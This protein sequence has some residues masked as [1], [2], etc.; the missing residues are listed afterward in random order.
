MYAQRSGKLS[1]AV[2]NP[3]PWR[4]DSHL[5]DPVVGAW[6]KEGGGEGGGG[7][8]CVGALCVQALTVMHS[9]NTSR[10]RCPC[11]CVSKPPPPPHP[12][13]GFYDAGDTLKLQFPLATSLAFLAWGALEFP[14]GYAAAGATEVGGCGRGWESRRHLRSHA[15]GLVQP[16]PPSLCLPPP[17]L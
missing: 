12:P 6:G 7:A 3:I 5:N 2:A 14:Q 16:S 15:G 13:G 1:G 9:S 11:A 10:V 17:P 8:C 4:S